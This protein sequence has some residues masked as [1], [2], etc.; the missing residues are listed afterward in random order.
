M[1]IFMKKEIDLPFGINPVDW[2]NFHGSFKDIFKDFKPTPHFKSETEVCFLNPENLVDV[3]RT[4]F[5]LQPSHLVNVLQPNDLHE[6]PR[7]SARLRL[8]ALPRGGRRRLLQHQ[9]RWLK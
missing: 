6:A 7:R 3:N 5:H 9:M 2:F 1:W 8:Q 4:T